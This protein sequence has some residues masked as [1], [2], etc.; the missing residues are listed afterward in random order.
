ML[1]LPHDEIETEKDSFSL[2]ESQTPS[3]FAFCS[4]NSN[5]INVVVLDS[6]KL[7]TQIDGARLR[8]VRCIYDGNLLKEV[9]ISS[10]SCKSLLDSCHGY[11]RDGT[12][13]FASS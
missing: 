13:R 2:L 6:G 10:F 7:Y 12:T 3:L 1:S 8:S 11:S 4:T 5:K 9:I